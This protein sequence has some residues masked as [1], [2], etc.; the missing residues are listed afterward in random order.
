[1]RGSLLSLVFIALMSI[2]TFAIVNGNANPNSWGILKKIEPQLVK[3]TFFGPGIRISRCSG[4]LVTQKA[5]LTAA[6]CLINKLG[7]PSP[8]SI[9]FYNNGAETQFSMN[10]H[11]ISY[12]VITHPD[13]EVGEAKDIQ[14]DLGLIILNEGVFTDQQIKPIA[15]GGDGAFDRPGDLKLRRST[16]F[17]TSSLHMDTLAALNVKLDAFREKKNELLFKTLNSK[18]QTCKGD[19]GGPVMQFH[20]NHFKVYGVVSKGF[21]TEGDCGS[22]FLITYIDEENKKWIESY[23]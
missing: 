7:R 11:A 10:S 5:I 8:D 9:T 19:S 22:K 20:R 1:M 18:Q 16:V 12:E 3:I 6:H 14:G 2:D 17:G 21:H 23:L 15:I 13:F 4:L